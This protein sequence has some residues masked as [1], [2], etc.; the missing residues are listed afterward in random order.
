MRII[1]G[2][3][4]GRRINAP[5]G[6]TS[7]PT[8]DRTR[9]ALFNILSARDDFEFEGARVIDLFAGS[10]GLGFEALSRGADWCLFVETDAAARGAIRDT[11]ETL[12]LFGQTR[13]HRRSATALGSKPASAGAPFT[14]AF[15]DPPYRQD[16]CT[17]AL[18]ELA[19]GDWLA[20]NALV[21]VEQAK[22]EPPAEAAL[23]R[24]IDRRTYG[25]AQIGIYLFAS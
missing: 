25:A 22:D 12:S 23:Y 3:F 10:G 17:P 18:H 2:K 6:L 9:E 8:A 21:V 16:L 11:I 24:E 1:G 4:S 20:P 5:K 19:G 15:L 7:R 14:L 13:I